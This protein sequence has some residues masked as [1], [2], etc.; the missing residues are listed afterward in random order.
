M[1]SNVIRTTSFAQYV[2]YTIHTAE[3]VFIRIFLFFPFLSTIYLLLSCKTTLID[4]QK[5]YIYI[6]NEVYPV[7]NIFHRTHAK[8]KKGVVGWGKRTGK[9]LYANSIILK[10]VFKFHFAMCDILRKPYLQCYLMFC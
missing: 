5:L 8:L 3:H 4:Q 7:K 2:Q 10:C 6:L 1:Q 9:I